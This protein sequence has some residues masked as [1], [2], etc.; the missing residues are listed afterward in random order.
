MHMQTKE[1]REVIV[2]GELNADLILDGLEGRL[3]EVGKEIIAGSMT[4]TLGSSSAIFASNLSSLGTK[5]R[6]V[7]MTGNDLFAD[8]VV[9]S[10]EEK[11]VAT[12][13][14]IR[15]DTFRTGVTVACSYGNDRAMVTHPGAMEH[16]TA[17]MVPGALFR[18][19]NHLHLSSVFLQKGIRPGLNELFSRARSSGMTTSCDPQWDPDEK[20]DLDI[21]NFLPLV[22]VFLPNREE[23]LHLT[24]AATLNDAL[25]SVAGYANMVAVKMGEEGAMLWSDGRTI[26]QPVFPN[27]RIV[28]TIGAGDSFDAGFIHGYIRNAPPEECLRLGALAGA[29]NTTGAG[30]TTAFP[31]LEAVRETARRVFNAE[32]Q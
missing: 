27:S 6:F 10:L 4:L 13:D 5:V 26:R 30:G 14:V 7:G 9:G 28:D 8:L 18:Q 20:W 16:L 19:G 15:S 31:G 22:D 12:S 32:M 17:S 11:G 1:S 29:I 23:L 21:V 3:P 2:V 24:G 25:S